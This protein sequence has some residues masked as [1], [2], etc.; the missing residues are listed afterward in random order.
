MADEKS[1]DI[2]NPPKRVTNPGAPEVTGYQEYPR[3]LHK[4]N[5]EYVVVTSD[6]EKAEKLDAGFFLSVEDAKAAKKS[7]YTKAE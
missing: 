4:A 1:F 3:H 7:K 2:S 6:S 5:G